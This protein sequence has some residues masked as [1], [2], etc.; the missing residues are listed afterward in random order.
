MGGRQPVHERWAEAGGG[1]TGKPF[2]GGVDEPP[3]IDYLWAVAR[4]DLRLSEAEFWPLTLFELNL[5][6]ERHQEC[7][8]FEAALHGVELKAQRYST[9]FE[10]DAFFSK[11][12]NAQPK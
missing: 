12:S 8:K 9:S 11:F 4:Y 10:I 5:L 3:D 6:L 2:D 7:C 1:R